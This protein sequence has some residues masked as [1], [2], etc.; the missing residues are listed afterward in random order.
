LGSTT[1]TS[2]RQWALGSVPLRRRVAVAVAPQRP[3]RQ[4]S[5]A[6]C[7]HGLA[8]SW[9]ARLHPSG[10]PHRHRPVTT[11]GCWNVKTAGSSACCLLGALAARLLL[12]APS[13]V[14]TAGSLTGDQR[15]EVEAAHASPLA[16]DSGSSRK[17]KRKVHGYGKGRQFRNC[18]V[19]VKYR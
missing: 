6:S 11:V 16:M 2:E 17:A 14:K 7:P 10:S 12:L 18:E 8:P 5:G 4:T 15:V 13:G 3:E 19:V 1:P 9:F